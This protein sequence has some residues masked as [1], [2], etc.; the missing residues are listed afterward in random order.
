MICKLDYRARTLSFGGDGPVIMFSDNDL[1]QL[2]SDETLA[3]LEGHK[4]AR[5]VSVTIELLFPMSHTN[6]RDTDE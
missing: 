1:R 3:F 4:D 5:F 6:R 2:L